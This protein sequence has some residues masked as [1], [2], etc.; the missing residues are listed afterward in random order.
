MPDEL[1]KNLRALFQEPSPCLPEEPFLSN[2]LALVRR[3]RS[4][5]VSQ[6]ILILL[7]TVSCCG[8]LSRFIIKCSI[9]LSDYL[10]RIFGAAGMFLSKP[11]GILTGVLCCGL[12]LLIF[13][14]R[15]ISRLA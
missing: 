8:F 6:Q 3:H 9:L 12:L 11:A 14:R 4:L 5:R 7:L 2:T 15:L 10:D 13:N 1:D